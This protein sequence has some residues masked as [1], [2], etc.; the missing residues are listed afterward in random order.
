M[1]QRTAIFEAIR[2]RLAA[3]PD[4]AASGKV[5]RGRT[6]PVRQEALPA[7]SLTWT[8]DD[9]QVTPRPCS[10][11]AGE[12]GYDRVLPVS[13]VV[14]LRDTDTDAAFDVLAEKIETALAADISLGG[15][16]IECLLESSRYFVNPQTGLPLCVGRLVYRVHYKTQAN[17]A[18]PAI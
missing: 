2:A 12:L 16:A 6:E 11:P 17:P 18:L 5:K 7:I 13:I 10:G 8:D 14:H 9:E 15:L 3:I 4:F 1:H